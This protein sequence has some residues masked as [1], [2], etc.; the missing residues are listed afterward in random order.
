M[1]LKDKKILVLGKGRTGTSTAA[2]LERMEAKPIL[3]DEREDGPFTDLN[4]RDY[5]LVVQSPGISRQHPFLERCDEEGIPVTNEI[6]LASLSAESPIIGVTGTN[7]KTTIVNLL[8]HILTGCGRNSAL[9]GNVGT[10]FADL[11]GRGYDTYVLELSSYQLEAVDTFRPKIAIVSNLTPDHLERHKTME[12]YL[13]IKTRIY[14]NMGPEGTVILNADDEWLRSLAPKGPRV[15]WFS[16]KRKVEGIYESRGRILLNLGKERDLMA[17]SELT[18][19]GG[20][21]VENAMAV[22][23][24]ALVLGERETCI[25]EGARNF[26]GVE[27]RLEFIREI[28]GVGYY[29]DSKSTNPDASITAIRAFSGRRTLLILGGS[30][31]EVHYRELA[32]TIC[33]H[34]VL[35]VLQGATGDE[36]LGI[37]EEA[38]CREYLQGKD[39]KEALDLARQEARSGDVILLSPA[40][41]SFDQFKNF[42]HRGETFKR[43]V[44]EI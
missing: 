40:C 43:Y 13:A 18:I 35:P 2:F 29:N 38:G 21:N 32:E 37:L 1:E 6:E 44:W 12:R 14:R 17:S 7:G 10:P 16:R 20:H 4:P 39:L 36:I 5:D 27:H 3:A 41:A 19:L 15:L 31:K 8:Q 34:D 24:A 28:G 30:A 11:A 23:L 25:L 9:V 42:E 22:I 33:N 26:P